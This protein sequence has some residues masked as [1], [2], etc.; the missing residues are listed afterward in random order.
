ME[1]ISHNGIIWIDIKNP[2]KQDIEYLASCYNI[3]QIILN[4]IIPPS[5]RSKVEKFDHSLYLVL[6]FPVFLRNEEKTTTRE[7]DIIVNKDFI[8]TSHY[9]SIIPLKEIFD[10]CRLYKEQREKYMSQGTGFLLYQITENMLRHCLPK[11]DHIA[12]KID[13]AE[14]KIFSGHEKDMVERLSII[15]R[16]I[17]DMGKAIKPQQSVLKSLNKHAPQFFGTKSRLYFED[18]LGSYQ[19]VRSTLEF[20]QRIIQ[21]LCQTNESLLSNKVSEIMKILTIVSF[22]TFPL[23]VI[24]GFFGMNVFANYQFQESKITLSISRIKNNIILCAGYYAFKH[25]YNGCFI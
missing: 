20:H 23:S 7:I 12:E 11:L 8:I 2:Q 25:N 1:R 18:L 10:R 13:I 14:E 9:N 15:K 24:T 22:I 16:D 4:E 21:S 5:Y 19:H 17:L 6:Y 3:H